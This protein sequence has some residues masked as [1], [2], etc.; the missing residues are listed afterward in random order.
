MEGQLPKELL[1][2]LPLGRATTGG[3]RG[4]FIFPCVCSDCLYD[5]HVQQAQ[6][7]PSRHP[8]PTSSLPTD[9]G[10]LRA[11]PPIPPQGN[12]AASRSLK[13]MPFALLV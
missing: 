12:M 8:S 9:T 5:A 3:R 7:L 1:T 4:D 2:W 13:V 6:K 10:Y 11:G